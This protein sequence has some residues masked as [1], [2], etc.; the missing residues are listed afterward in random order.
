[1]GL[2]GSSHES[3]TLHDYLRVV[4]RRKWIILQ[5]VVIVP[6]VA[7]SLATRQDA[8]YKATAD[9]LINTR[10]VSG[11]L[12]GVGSLN[13]Q[14]PVRLAQTQAELAQSLEVAKNV[15]R[16]TQAD[17]SPARFL[18]IASATPYTDSD[19]IGLSVVDTSRS[20]AVRLAT[21][22]AQEFTEYRSALDTADLD[23][24]L[25]GVQDRLLTITDKESPL[26]QR[27]LER[28][29]QLQELKALQAQPLT[30]VRPATAASQVA[31]R[32]L[33]NGL[34]GLLLGLVLGFGLAFLREALDTRVRTAEEVADALDLTLLAR[35]PAPPKR[36]AAKDGLVMLDV[37][38]TRE[39]EAFRMLRTNLEF[40][41]LERGARVI[42]V[43]SAVESEGK[44]TTASNLALALARA[45]RHVAL[46]D[47]DLRRPY[48]DRFFGLRGAP[49]LTQV[50]LGHVELDVALTTIAITDSLTSP[51]TGPGRVGANG[52]GNG[53]G[54]VAGVLEVL[55]SGPIP[56]DAGEF[57]GTHAVSAI[58]EKLRERADFVIIDAP[59]LLNVGDAMALSSKVDGLI[60]VTRLKVLRRG[61]LKELQRLLTNIPAQPLGFVVTGAEV[62]KGYGYGY[63]YEDY[64]RTRVP[65]TE[66]ERARW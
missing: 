1:M 44:S 46:A 48:L 41:N 15:V 25:A 45:G 2:T 39:A 29:Q 36:L 64:G 61:T 40:T 18:E 13:Y 58:I 20:R 24:A 4:R 42:M 60:L 34:L 50:A 55:P 37:P 3:A 10:D 49:G 28:E 22:Y 47:L 21:A 9:V 66:Q 63:E 16:T 59:P 56:P 38:R 7:V 26:Y 8:L 27:L 43:T 12:T 54:R 31:P 19:L 5:A 35:L 62:E 14:D 51:P 11:S 33:R 53:H 17:I 65:R 52:G 6:I 57:V 32:P 30:L 23:E